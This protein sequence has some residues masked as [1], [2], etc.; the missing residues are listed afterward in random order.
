MKKFRCVV[1]DFDGTLVDTNSLKKDGFLFVAASYS[2]G[3]LAMQKI[4]EKSEG[5]RYERMAA[6]SSSVIGTESVDELVRK[7][8]QKVDLAVAKA[9]SLPGAEQLL[10]YLKNLGV[11]IILSSATPLPNL[12][13]IIDHRNWN[14]F[15]D[16][17]FG[18]PATKVETLRHLI[19]KEKLSCSEI[20]IV[21][22]GIDD[23][24]S[25][26]LLGCDFFA[27]GEARGTPLNGRKYKLNELRAILGNK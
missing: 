10:T 22:D 19:I 9:E 7:Y 14:R 15:F 5:N 6:F 26:R 21:G 17:I 23:R 2:G 11:L 12:K 4:L 3:T 13:K 16:H 18:G 27:V 24:D 25:A 8:S 20:A 1:F